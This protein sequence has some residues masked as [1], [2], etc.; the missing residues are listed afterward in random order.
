MFVGYINSFSLKINLDCNNCNFQ[1]FVRQ[2]NRIQQTHITPLQS[3]SNTTASAMPISSSRRLWQQPTKGKF[4]FKSTRNPQELLG[5]I[6]GKMCPQPSNTPIGKP[7]LSLPDW[8][9]RREK[10]HTCTQ[11][12]KERQSPWHRTHGKLWPTCQDGRG[13]QEPRVL[14]DQ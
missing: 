11:G 13:S 5:A 10:G 4:E 8:R 7:R 3:S 9:S 2:T 12:S 6:S 14:G 1:L